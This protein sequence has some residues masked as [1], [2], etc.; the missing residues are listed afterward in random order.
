MSDFDESFLRRRF[1]DLSGQAESGGYYTYSDFLSPAEQALLLQM[2]RE[3]LVAS[4]SLSGG[5]ASAERKLAAF[6]SEEEFGYP[7]VFPAVWI[8]IAP[9]D[10]KFAE[11]LTHRDFLGS[12][13][14]LG[15]GREVLGDILLHDGEGH[16]FAGEKIAPYIVG[17]LEKVRRTAVICRIE[18]A[19]PAVVTLPPDA[20]ERVAAGERLDALVAAVFSLS[21]SESARLIER[22]LVALDGRPAEKLSASPNPGT[23]VSVRGFGRF[24][25]EG[26][27]GDTR[28]G[29]LRVRVRIYR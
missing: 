12:L 10:R 1:C 21:R 4:V 16:L 14:G 6:G 11:P 13:I 25:Y 8:G 2:K 26:I 19:P 9:K 24:L 23:M 27:V 3:G 18:D 15:I 22:G 20:E 5:F 28:K 29:R 17:N 7:P